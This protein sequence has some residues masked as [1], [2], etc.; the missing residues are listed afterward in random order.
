MQVAS[1]WVAV[2]KLGCCRQKKY[3]GHGYLIRVHPLFHI[4]V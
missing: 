4:A 1:A 2:Q 3:S